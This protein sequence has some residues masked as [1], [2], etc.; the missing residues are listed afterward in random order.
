MFIDDKPLHQVLSKDRLESNKFYF[1]YANAKIYLA[2]DP[3]NRKV[4]ATVAAFA[5]ESMASDVL[6][7]NIT[8]EKYASAAQKGAIHAREAT[9]LDYRELRGTLE[10]RCRD[11][12]RD[13][14]P[15]S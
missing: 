11:Q 1:D 14:R 15:R 3:R 2:D 8:V 9:G 12:H 4:E 6:I 10:Q 5:F 13:R 7:R